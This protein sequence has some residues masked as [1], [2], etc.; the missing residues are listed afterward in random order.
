M[1]GGYVRGLARLRRT[2]PHHRV[3]LGKGQLLALGC[4]GVALV[5]RLLLNPVLH[6]NYLFIT[7]FPAVLVSAVWGGTRA[8][9]AALALSLV[10]TG[11][12]WI[13]LRGAMQPRAIQ[14]WGGLAAFM[15]FGGTLVLVAD[16]LRG[17][18]KDLSSSE[19]RARLLAAEMKH[20]VKN[21][22]AMV[23]ALSRQTARSAASVE[24]Y[25]ALMEGRLGALARAQDLVS[26]NSAEAADLATLL[27]Q[28]LAPY[29]L[30]RFEIS[31]PAVQLPPDTLPMIALLVHELATNATKHGALSVFRGSVKLAWEPEAERL[32]MNWKERGGP[33][34]RH[35]ESVGFGSRLV[36][37]AFP[38]ERGT[39]SIGYEPDG[40][41]CRV[42][43]PNAATLAERRFS[44]ARRYTCTDL[45]RY[46]PDLGCR[47]GGG[48]RRRFNLEPRIEF[49]AVAP[50][51]GIADV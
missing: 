14:T 7:F 29:D 31:G 37:S 30:N 45:L 3:S 20:R 34:V 16:L 5:L 19:E 44:P 1:L 2:I 25:Q 49:T 51:R 38:A 17:A 26:E 23:T 9:L 13:D 42:R 33:T 22:L 12:G 8:G 36:A 47:H 27:R 35:P 18:L 4:V 48:A 10:V 24:A 21:T 50:T 15:V 41:R 40:V 6:N 11:F 43:D 39:A 28:V 46:R 32:I